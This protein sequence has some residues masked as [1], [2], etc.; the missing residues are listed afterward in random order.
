MNGIKKTFTSQIWLQAY[1]RNQ[2]NNFAFCVFQEFDGNTNR[3]TV[4][5]HELNPPVRARYIRFRPTAW[6]LQV[7]MR[8]EVY[9]CPGTRSHI[10]S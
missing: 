8:V 3:D 4:V 10:K 9:G 7:S 2:F 6:N 5:K 1:L